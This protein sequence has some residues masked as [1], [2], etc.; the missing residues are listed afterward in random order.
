MDLHTHNTPHKS[1]VSFCQDHVRMA[2]TRED[3]EGKKQE[4]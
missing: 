2:K 3:E 4:E 1:I